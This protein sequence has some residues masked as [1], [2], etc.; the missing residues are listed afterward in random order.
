MTT[1][2]IRVGLIGLS[3]SGSWASNAHL[4]YLRKSSKYT[5]TALC[6][7]SVDAAHAAIKAYDLPPSTKAYGSYQDLA[8]DPDIDL[9]VCSVRVDKHYEAV[10]P[11]IKAGKSCY[12]EWPLGKDLAEAE[13]LA[14]LAREKCVR[15]M[16]GLQAH[17]SP[18]VRKVKE[19]VEGGK[20]GK[21]LS[22]DFVGA[23]Y[24]FGQQELAKYRYLNE[25]EVGGNMVTIHFSH[26]K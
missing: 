4:P 26:C 13:K 11:A 19:L 8:D 22:V 12:C 9:V 7:S 14:E 20:V 5:I 15:T 24:N 18:V 1:N 25:R 3:A 21:V 6:N 2:R 10:M 17:H 16:V 23:A